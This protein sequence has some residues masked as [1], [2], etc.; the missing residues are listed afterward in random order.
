[1]SASFNRRHVALAQADIAERAGR[2]DDALAAYSVA[3]AECERS[4]YNDPV[5]VY[6]MSF[7]WQRRAELFL[8]LS[9]PDVVA[10]QAE[11]DALLPY[12]QKAKATWYLG[13]LRTWAEERGLAFQIADD[14][15]T[16]ALSA[17][18]HLT[19]R[20]LE[21]ARLVAQGL[22]NREIGTRLT[23]SVRTAE[24]HVEQIRAKLGFKTRAQIASWMTERYGARTS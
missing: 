24:S 15:P 22:T 21:V 4:H 3:L 11:F 10:A 6:F 12:W 19:R 16:A 2:I 5:A 7:I 9:P 8:R 13:Q 23:L 17:P 18:R 20:E 14:A 1:V